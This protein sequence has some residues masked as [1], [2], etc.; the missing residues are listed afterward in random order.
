MHRHEGVGQ[1]L[2]QL[3]LRGS[4]TSTRSLRDGA[5]DL[6]HHLLAHEKPFARMVAPE[7]GHVGDLCSL[8]HFWYFRHRSSVVLFIG[9][10][11]APF[12]RLFM[13]LCVSWTFMGR[14]QQ[15]DVPWWSV[16]CTAQRES[17]VAL[18]PQ[19]RL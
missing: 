6:L 2:H 3:L 4:L 8:C 16:C 13:C 11:M 14:V 1:R 12:V 19:T 9:H 10:L 7:Q 17:M 18:A 15:T 5:G